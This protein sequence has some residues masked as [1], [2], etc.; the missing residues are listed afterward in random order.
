MVASRDLSF[1]WGI[2]TIRRSVLFNFVRA[3]INAK[4][5]AKDKW[6]VFQ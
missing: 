1:L 3:E 5:F 4:I 2:A 6:G